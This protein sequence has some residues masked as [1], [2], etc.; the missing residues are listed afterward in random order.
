MVRQLLKSSLVAAVVD[1]LCRGGGDG[2]AAHAAGVLRS[3]YHHAALMWVL[4]CG[5]EG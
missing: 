5:A 1:F 2:S 4:M 3:H